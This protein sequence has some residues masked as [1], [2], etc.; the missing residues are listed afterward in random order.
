MILSGKVFLVLLIFQGT[1]FGKS[2]LITTF[3]IN[4]AKTNFN[5]LKIFL[6][7]KTS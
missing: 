2:K 5:P 6:I 3:M 1:Y 4:L 7:T